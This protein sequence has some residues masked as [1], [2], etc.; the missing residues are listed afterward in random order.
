MFTAHRTGIFSF[1]F[2]SADFICLFRG[3]ELG[4]SDRAR[5]IGISSI[6]ELPIIL[7]RN[8][9]A[10]PPDTDQLRTIG[11]LDSF[12]AA[13]GMFMDPADIN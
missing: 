9:G 5:R 3:A 13:S 1:E 4:Q 11:M 12:L 6:F 2:L 8:G 10:E 7:R